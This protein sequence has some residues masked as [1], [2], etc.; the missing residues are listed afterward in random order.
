MSWAILNSPLQLKE[1]QENGCMQNKFCLYV[2]YFSS[3]D[4][5]SDQNGSVLMRCHYINDVM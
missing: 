4:I 5:L 2:R 1:Q 3:A